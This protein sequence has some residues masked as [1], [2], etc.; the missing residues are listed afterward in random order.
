MRKIVCG[1]LCVTMMFSMVACSNRVG[2]RDGSRE[3]GSRNGEAEAELRTDLD[4]IEKLFPTLEGVTE[5]EWE[6]KPL[7]SGDSFV[8]DPHDSLCQ[9]YIILSDEAAEKYASS[10][11]WTD[12]SPKV[13][14]EVVTE[15]EGN[16]K[17]SHD[18][19]VEVYNGNLKGN[20]WIDG[21]TILFTLID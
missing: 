10:Y 12:V 11:E 6:C 15:R 14:F 19:E 20:A 16:W 1:I 2:S 18:F 5:A 4:G 21:N 8:P 3:S 7:G 17:A 9:G 13:D